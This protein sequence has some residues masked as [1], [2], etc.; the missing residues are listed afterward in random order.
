ML[1]CCCSTTLYIYYNTLF[2][3]SQIYKNRRGKIPRPMAIIVLVRFIAAYNKTQKNKKWLITFYLLCSCFGR[4]SRIRTH[5]RS[6]G[7]CYPSF[8]YHYS[9]HYQRILCLWSGVHLHHAAAF[10]SLDGRL[11]TLYGLQYCIPSVLT[12]Y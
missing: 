11:S 12:S 3:K 5:T 6:F 9:F 7:R 10:G 8:A 2:G 4:G 1:N